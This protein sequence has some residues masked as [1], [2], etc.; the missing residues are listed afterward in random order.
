MQVA[1][2]DAVYLFHIHHFDTP[3]PGDLAAAIEPL[4]P[5]IT[6]SSIVKAGV[7]ILDDAE[8][9]E[10]FADDMAPQCAPADSPVWRLSCPCA[11]LCMRT[12]GAAVLGLPPDCQGHC[13][14]RYHVPA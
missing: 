13:H 12:T 4:R 9:L 7:G 2:G 11:H 1:G 3:T 8:M 6:S 5:L 14:G 10:R